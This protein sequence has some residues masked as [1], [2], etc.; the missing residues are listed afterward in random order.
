MASGV[1]SILE[2]EETIPANFPHGTTIRKFSRG[3]AN[4]EPASKD[5][6]V[7][8]D[9]NDE[10][11]MSDN[12]NDVQ[13]Y[14]PPQSEFYLAHFSRAKPICHVHLSKIPAVHVMFFR[15]IYPILM[16]PVLA[17]S[18]QPEPQIKEAANYIQRYC[19]KSRCRTDPHLAD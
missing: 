14:T 1:T 16:F 8:E 11:Y 3:F 18:F 4:A 15:D 2:V 12:T 9:E 6:N 7:L 13:I 19:C 10:D 5:T 17:P